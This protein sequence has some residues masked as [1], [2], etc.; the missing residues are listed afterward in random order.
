MPAIVASQQA[1]I[2]CASKDDSYIK[3]MHSK[4]IKIFQHIF[5]KC[6]KVITIININDLQVEILLSY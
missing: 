2:K 3:I 5:G 4:V 1:L 6:L